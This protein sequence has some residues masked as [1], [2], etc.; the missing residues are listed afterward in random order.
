VAVYITD[1][2]DFNSRGEISFHGVINGIKA[3][4]KKFPQSE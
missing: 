3:L 1:A 2:K 4:N